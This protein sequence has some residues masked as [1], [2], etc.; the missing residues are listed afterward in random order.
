MMMIVKTV[1][2]NIVILLPLPVKDGVGGVVEVVITLG[3][4][5]WREEN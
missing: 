2:L 1:G 4:M 3:V 5:T